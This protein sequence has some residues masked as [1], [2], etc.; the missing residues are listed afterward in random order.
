MSTL[1]LGSVRLLHRT[2]LDGGLA[3]AN[4]WPAKLKS[5][6]PAVS[7]IKPDHRPAREVA[8]LVQTADGL[9][10]VKGPPRI[11]LSVQCRL[12]TTTSTPPMRQSDDGL[13]HSLHDPYIPIRAL[14]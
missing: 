2:G 4:C 9:R 8:A 7:R 1:R 3:D 5:L 10:G 14:V 11:L 12:Q 13:S 6:A